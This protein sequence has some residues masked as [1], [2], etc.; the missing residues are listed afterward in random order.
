MLHSA[1]LQRHDPVEQLQLIAVEEFLP[2]STSPVS[3]VPQPNQPNHLCGEKFF[4]L[5]GEKPKL[6]SGW[7][8]GPELHK[9]ADRAD[10]SVLI[11]PG[12]C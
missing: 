5:C 8:N 10:Q 6:Q 11:F 1:K 7:W 2:G 3:Q 4:H 12:R 9:R